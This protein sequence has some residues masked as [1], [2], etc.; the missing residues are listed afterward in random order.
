[1]GQFE[2]QTEVISTGVGHPT[3]YKR[4]IDVMEVMEANAFE[5]V[6]LLPHI[7]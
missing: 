6:A 1:M 2:P 4:Y 5:C 7:I 3:T